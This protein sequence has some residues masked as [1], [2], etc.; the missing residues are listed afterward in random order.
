MRIERQDVMTYGAPLLFVAAA[1]LAGSKRL[2]KHFP[3]ASQKGLVCSTALGSA[4]VIAS[5]LKNS[6]EGCDYDRRVYSIA[7]LA[8]TAIAAPALAKS[9]LGRADLNF[10]ASLR[11]AFIQ[12]V[13]FGSVDFG[14][15][16]MEKA[17]VIPPIAPEPEAD[18]PT[19]QQQNYIDA[20]PLDA[21]SVI[22]QCLSNADISK[23]ALTCKR[24]QDVVETPQIQMHLAE[25]F[26]F[27]PK[28][29]NRYFGDVGEAPPLPPDIMGILRSPCPYWEGRII[30]NTHLLVLIPQT[31]NGQP[32]TLDLLGEII[33][34]PKGGGHSAKYYR[35]SFVLNELGDR[36]I[37]SSYWA[38]IT[39]DVIP[40]SRSK[41]Y[42]EQQALLEDPYAVP[43][44]LEIAT[45]ILMHYT[46]T[47]ERLYSDNTNTF[48]RCQ[49]TTNNNS[50]V[51]VGSFGPSGLN[52][53]DVLIH[54]PRGG[55]DSRIG[56][57][58]LSCVLRL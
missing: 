58:G 5:G 14:S 44:A 49:E 27:G 51:V 38:L 48:T 18:I 56:S 35:A 32:F 7:G 40:N 23:A 55:G 26:A 1:F 30:A 12:G 52:V 54:G 28:D 13:I 2:I 43:G 16:F 45:G 34:A 46:Q 22:F 4:G 20:V 24:F 41:T 57:Y 36:G 33:K 6:G 37:T 19:P 25:N 3:G 42:T 29:W 11:F 47:V 15:S 53:F 21:I 8:I 17:D 50:R 39:K 10:R 9:L 31:V